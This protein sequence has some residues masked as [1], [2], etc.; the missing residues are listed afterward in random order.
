MADLIQ[1]ALAEHLALAAK[2]GRNCRPA[3]RM[4]EGAL[5]CTGQGRKLLTFGN[6]GSAADASTGGGNAGKIP[7]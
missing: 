1:S 7:A 4:W 2:W 6:G 3:L 5:R